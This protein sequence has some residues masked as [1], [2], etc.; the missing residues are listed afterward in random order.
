MFQIYN[1]RVF[2]ILKVLNIIIK[3]VRS[4]ISFK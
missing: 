1:F 4:L 3:G 2:T